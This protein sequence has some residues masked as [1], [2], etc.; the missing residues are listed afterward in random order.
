M[1][2][3]GSPLG[4]DRSAIT[5]FPEAVDADHEYRIWNTQFIRYAGY[6]VPDGSVLG[7]PATVDFTEVCTELGWE[8][9]K[10]RSPFD[11]LPLVLQA[12]GGSPQVFELEPKD[13]LEVCLTHPK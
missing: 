7:D 2:G 3:C 13:V 5:V 11:V 10:E 6:R 9:P 12:N 8:P 1:C 4:L